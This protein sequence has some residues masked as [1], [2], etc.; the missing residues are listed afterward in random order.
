MKR[1]FVAYLLFLLCL[2]CF[3]G[4]VETPVDEKFSEFKSEYHNP[5]AILPS[6][7]Y[8]GKKEMETKGAYRTYYLWKEK[9]SGKYIMIHVLHPNGS[10]S[11]PENIKWIDRDSA[12][13]SEGNIAAYDYLHERPASVITELDKPLPTCYVVAQEFYLDDERKEA[14]YKMLISPDDTCLLTYED[15]I[16]ELNRVANMR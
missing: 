5:I 3:G 11:F 9:T 14:M 7:D 8:V 2:S 4:K 10:K 15:T 1:F 13:Y 16:R 6:Y 12:I